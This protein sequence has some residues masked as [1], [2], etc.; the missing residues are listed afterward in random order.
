MGFYLNKKNNHIIT[1]YIGI[2]FASGMAT[3]IQSIPLGFAL[4]AVVCASP[5][6]DPN[7]NDLFEED[8]HLDAE[9]LQLVK[10]HY[11]SFQEAESEAQQRGV[12]ISVRKW[13]VY[14]ED[15]KFIVPYTLHSSLS[16]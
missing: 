12:G 8:I 1:L 3:L 9:T 10:T 2:K 16:S 6:T 13:D 4:I 7:F 5:V 11:P 15:G 14:Q